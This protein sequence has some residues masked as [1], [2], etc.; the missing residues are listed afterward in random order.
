MVEDM[1]A[2]PMDVPG[3]RW[4]HL[5]RKRSSQ[6]DFGR[7]G[8]IAIDFNIVFVLFYRYQY[9]GF[10]REATSYPVFDDARD[11]GGDRFYEPRFGGMDRGG[12]YRGR[13]R[14][15]YGMRGR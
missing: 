13:G 11:R 15:D 1:E 10:P 6:S 3:P 14:P 5:I 7:A 9:R 4:A 12:G 8:K 2:R